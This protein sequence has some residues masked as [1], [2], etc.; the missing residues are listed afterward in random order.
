MNWYHSIRKKIYF[1]FPLLDRY[2]TLKQFIKFTLVGTTNSAIDFSVYLILTRFFSVHLILANFCSF[3]IAVTW[4]FFINKKWTFRN[5]HGD[6]AKQYIKFFIT[7]TIGI[8]IQTLILS[9]FVYVF[10]VHDVLGKLIAIV[11]TSFWNFSIS[12]IWTFR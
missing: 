2:H 11:I 7:N 6:H 8:I 4:S 9:V 3:S 12:K 1:Y 5:T 10:K